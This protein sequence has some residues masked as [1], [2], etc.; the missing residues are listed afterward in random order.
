MK[1]DAKPMNMPRLSSKRGTQFSMSGTLLKRTWTAPDQNVALLLDHDEV[2][3]AIL[4]LAHERVR[5]E[6][7]EDVGEQAACLLEGSTSRRRVR[8]RSSGMRPADSANSLDAPR[9]QSWC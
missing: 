8:S 9:R 4:V 2:H 7:E 6:V 3:A 1:N 5:D